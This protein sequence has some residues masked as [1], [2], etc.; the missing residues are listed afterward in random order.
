MGSRSL[1]ASSGRSA[2]S[3]SSARSRPGSSTAVGNRL[4]GASESV[5]RAQFETWLHGG[6]ARLDDARLVRHLRL[7]IDALNRTSEK[8]CASFG[9]ESLGGKAIDDDT[10]QHLITSL[11]QAGM[12]E[13]VGLNVD[14]IEAELRGSP[15]AVSISSADS[16]PIFEQM[17]GA[18]TPGQM[19]TL[20]ALTAGSTVADREMCAAIRGLYGQ[21]LNLDSASLAVLARIDVSQ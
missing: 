21:S 9:R 19:Q 13:F 7:E 1:P 10:S 14:A 11:D 4:D 5:A 17:L 2:G 15:P 3:C 6:Y 12:V 20:T 8:D 18:L 16:G